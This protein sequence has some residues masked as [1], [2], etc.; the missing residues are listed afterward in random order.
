MR[1]ISPHITIP[2]FV[3]LSTKGSTELYPVNATH[4]TMRIP[5]NFSAF[6]LDAC[7]PA[8]KLLMGLWRSI[9]QAGNARINRVDIECDANAEGN[10]EEKDHWYNLGQGNPDR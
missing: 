1:T 7:H 4:K 9:T 6:P 10:P 2:P 3:G 8:S 5:N